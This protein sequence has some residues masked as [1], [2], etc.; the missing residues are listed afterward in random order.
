MKS[1]LYSPPEPMLRAAVWICL[2]ALLAV[3]CSDDPLETPK[4]DAGI[5][6]EHDDGIANGDISDIGD[7][8]AQP[9]ELLRS[10][11]TAGGKF[12]VR[13]VP[14]SEWLPFQELF[15]VTIYVYDSEEDGATALGDVVLDVRAVVEQFGNAM[16]TVPRISSTQDGGFLV[17]GLL[18]HVPLAWEIIVRVQR[19]AE[20]DRVIFETEH[21]GLDRQGELADPTGF[22]TATPDEGRSGGISQVL[23]NSFNAAGPHSDAP[24]GESARL[25]QFLAPAGDETLG[26]FKTP[27]LRNVALRAP[28]MHGAQ[29]ATLDEVMD[30]YADM[31]EDPVVGGRDPLLQPTNLDASEIDDLVAFMEALTGEP[32]SE[33]LQVKPASPA[34]P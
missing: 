11:W 9:D 29:F 20:N 26:A 25:L 8:N 12:F 33:L 2:L 21:V 27:G 15:A 3:G 1:L 16:T 30:F 34:G 6:V 31:Q 17:E 23:A 14:T 4:A 24:D 10:K 28:Y 18:F 13:Y 5:D 7:G 22:F 19:G 32:L